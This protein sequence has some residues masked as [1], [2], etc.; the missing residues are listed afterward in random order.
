MD[1]VSIRE[2][3]GAAVVEA[4]VKLKGLIGLSAV[5]VNKKTI[6]QIFI[7]ILKT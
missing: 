1:Q 7:K 4:T 6:T 3:L 5:P 2:A